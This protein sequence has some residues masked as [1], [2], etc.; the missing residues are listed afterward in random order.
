VNLFDMVA[1]GMDDDAI[2]SQVPMDDE[3]EARFLGEERAGI[4]SWSRSAAT[5]A[6][7]LAS[8]LASAEGEKRAML[9]RIEEEAYRAARRR[10]LAMMVVDREL[11]G[12][13]T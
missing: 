12:V 5:I 2:E 11:V 1:D 3:L 8:L 9:A 7:A 4:P 10:K 13:E 6:A